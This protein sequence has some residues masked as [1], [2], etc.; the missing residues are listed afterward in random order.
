MAARNLRGGN[1]AQ[2][3]PMEDSSS[4]YYLH[5]SENPSFQL[6]PQVLT[7]SNNIYWSRSITT[8]LLAKNKLAFINGNLLRSAEDDLLFPAWLRFNSMVVSWIRNS[9][10]P[11]IC[12]SIM[13]IDNAHEI[14][15]DLRDRF[16]QLDTAR[17]YQL[18][19]K[20]TSLTQGND[21]VNAYFTNLRILWDEYRHSQP[22]T[23]CVCGT[24]SNSA[25]KWQTYQE[26]ECSVQFL[27]GLNSSFS[28]IRS[29]ILS[30]IHLPSL[31][32]VFSLVLQEER[33]RTIDGN[34]SYN[35][36]VTSSIS[37]Q[38]YSANVTQSYNKGKLCTH[39]GKTNHT[40]DRCFVL[41]GFPPSVGKG[42]GKF[43]NKDDN[44][45]KFV[46]YVE[47]S[48]DE[49]DKTAISN[50]VVVPS[51]EQL[52]TSNPHWL[53]DTGATHHVYCDS[54]MFDTY[55]SVKNASVHLP[56]GATAPGAS[57]GIVIGS[58]SR[59][60]NL[61]TLETSH[62]EKHQDSSPSAVSSSSS[63]SVIPSS[64]IPCANVVTGIDIW[65]KR[66]GHLSYDKLKSMSDKAPSYSH[67]R[68]IG[69]LCSASTIQ[70]GRDKFS[71]RATKCVLLGYP[72]DYKATNSEI[73]ASSPQTSSSPP[74]TS[75]SPSHITPISDDLPSSSS[76][77]INTSSD[78]NISRTGRTI[79]PPSHLTDFICNSVSSSTPYRISAYFTLSKLSP[80][81]LKY[82]VLM[83][84]VYEPTTYNQA[85]Q[86]L[87]W[88]QAMQDELSAFARTETW[89]VTV[90]PLGKVPIDCK[91]VYKV[92]YNPDATRERYKARLVAKGFT[93]L[94][95]VDFLD[96]FSPMAK[97]T[98][99]KLLL[100]L[101]AIHGWSL[102]HLD[103]NN[104]FLYG[105]LEE[106][107]YMTLPPGYRVDWQTVEGATPQST[108]FCKLK[109][110]LYSLKQGSRQWYLKFSE[111][112]KG[113]GL[114]QSV[115]DHSF[116]FKNDQYGFFGIIV[117]VDDILIATTNPE[118]T[119]S[120]KSFISQHFKFKDL[121][122]PKYFLG[123]ELTRNTK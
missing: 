86:Y 91:C 68:V 69:C 76:N 110:S 57:Q 90:V 55:S 81:Y 80:E 123:V 49:Y 112:L 15:S 99:V 31:S 105:D 107:I 121:G 113:F 83:S 51:P 16:S 58:G 38:L 48:F 106:N 94:E 14:W 118:I 115:L 17:A 122:V 52:T 84:A 116:F 2:I 8:A 97:P 56:N 10:S 18:R 95:G 120:F 117:Y 109:K 82:I 78:S 45:T 88:Q 103:I 87:E 28:Q 62:P 20:I 35:S 40:V 47:N 53:L 73:P 63:A 71:H 22:I 34:T 70:N 93:Q 79:K 19:H 50:N 72:P 108:L 85:S 33:Q 6:V 5:P 29:S 61:Y 27:I 75:P 92:K 39:C 64:V 96:T 67:L 98:T 13:Y 36:S 66:L 23:W 12:S 111:V 43:N 102:S 4:P 101:A 32:K 7:D 59:I 42:K 1:A 100:A 21:D 44:F 54:S 37:E 25:S 60:G 46:N 3:L 26:E 77:P 30:M 89:F 104:A 24:C 114:Q 74:Q 65:H 119:E 41:H 11:Q 9:I